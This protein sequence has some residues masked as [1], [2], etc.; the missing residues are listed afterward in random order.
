M[1]P[2][3]LKCLLSVILL[4]AWSIRSAE[5]EPLAQSL[6]E[7]VT[8]NAVALITTNNQVQLFSFMGLSAQKN[9]QG[10]HS[11]AFQVTIG[12]NNPPI[13]LPNVPS[14]LPLS[15]RLAS[16]ATTV[17]NRIFLFGGYTVAQDH[18]EIS[19][20]DNFEFIPSKQQY[21]ALAATP[22]PTDD[23]IVLPY[24]NRYIYQIS[25]W[26]NDGNVNLVQVYDIK[27][28]TWAQASPFL[29]QP[30][31][32]H[33]GGIIG[34]QML[35]CDGVSVVAQVAVRRTFHRVQACYSGVINREDPYKIDWRKVAHPTGQG[36][37]RMAAAGVTLATKN[38]K[39]SG[40]LF[41]GGSDNPYNYNGIGY[42][43]EPSEPS[44]QVWFYDFATQMWSSAVL[45][46]RTMDHRGLLVDEQNQLAYILGG[47][48]EQQTVVNT[49]QSI[50]LNTLI[51]RPITSA[52]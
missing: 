13:V 12:S 44:D 50:N 51:L 25:G 19:S 36:R 48:A 14:S 43:G 26:H 39:Q 41:A 1:L 32:G 42:N 24:K 10:V 17:N 28:N 6:P 11:K 22:V 3:F 9:W 30:V 31:F 27:T 2:F 21:R 37:Y 47:M 52:K 34:N 16:V 15:G 23:A 7:P 38:R 18:S 40:V 8:N 33:A 29:G 49:I 35:V 46:R 45:P 5:L 20:P 4:V